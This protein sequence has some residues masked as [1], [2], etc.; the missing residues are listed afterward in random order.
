MSEP[1]RAPQ[2]AAPRGRKTRFPVNFAQLLAQLNEVAATDG[3]E[4]L[5][6][7]GRL[8][9]RFIAVDVGD[10]WIATNPEV[11]LHPPLGG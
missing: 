8:G 10:G 4:V 2:P 9:R 7:L 6:L 5:A 3:V 11:V 1:H